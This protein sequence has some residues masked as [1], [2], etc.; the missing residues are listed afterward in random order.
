M[1]QSQ[2][3]KLL[4]MYEYSVYDHKGLV[5]ATTDD[6]SHLVGSSEIA[7]EHPEEGKLL[8]MYECSAYRQSFTTITHTKL[9]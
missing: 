4:Y 3:C 9:A 2:S 8:Y 1:N 6:T 5:S 7:V